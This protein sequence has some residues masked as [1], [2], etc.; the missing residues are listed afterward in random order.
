MNVDIY[1]IIDVKRE[2]RDEEEIQMCQGG[3]WKTKN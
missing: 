3:S 1:V 2:D